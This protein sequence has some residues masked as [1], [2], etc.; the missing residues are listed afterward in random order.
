MDNQDQFIGMCKYILNDFIPQEDLT[1][2]NFKINYKLILDEIEKVI[3][4]DL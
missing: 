4:K 2:L 3:D 1:N